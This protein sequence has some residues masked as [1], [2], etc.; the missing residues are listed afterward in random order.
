MKSIQRNARLAGVLYLIITIAAIIA[1]MY[2]P[3]TLI[4]PGDA[5]ATVG[6]ISNSEMLF[7][8]GGI[9]SE[10]IVLLSEVILAVLLYVLLKPVNKT[11]SLVAA[12]SRLIMTTIHGFNLINYF[13]VL[14]IV[15]GAGFLSGF[16][17]GQLNSLAM[18]FLEAHSFGFTIGIAFLVI[19]VFVLGYLIYKS[20]YFPKI[21]G[22]LFII[23]GL[24]YLIDSFFLLL[25]P[26]Y[27]TTPIYIAIPIAIAEL[28]FPVWLLIKGV[29][30]EGW[31]TQT[32]KSA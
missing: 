8:F 23:A 19:H 24:G 22:I 32:E 17:A 29:N 4:V 9:G 27:T 21:I 1:H 10:L 14:I 15:G 16:D 12:V 18:L 11:L 2:V 3:S 25:I 30:K 28:V 20:G 7:R 6:N 5:T 26:S 31:K 13:F